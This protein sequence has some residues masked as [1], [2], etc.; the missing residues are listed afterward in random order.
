MGTQGAKGPRM[1]V[2]AEVFGKFNLKTEYK[3]PVY[4]KSELQIAE[5]KERMEKNFLFDSLSPIEKKTIL[6][7]IKPTTLHDGDVVIKQGDD[8]DYFYLVE[9]GELDCKKFLN[10]D[11]TQETYLKTYVAGESFG[12][13]ALLYNAPRAATITCKSKDSELWALDRKTFSHI[14]LDAV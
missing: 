12:E 11:D 7:A 5:I 3:P 14:I 6:D 10:P 1:S 9:S 13:L 2:S 4:P 8:G